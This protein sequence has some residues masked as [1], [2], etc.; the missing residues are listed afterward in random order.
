MKLEQAQWRLF[1]KKFFVVVVASVFMVTP[2]EGKCKNSVF[3]RCYRGDIMALRGIRLEMQFWLACAA[4][5]LV[6]VHR[7][8]I[9]GFKVICSMQSLENVLCIPHHC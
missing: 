1:V 5:T 7:E 3:S 4:F 9:A 2:G 6:P 8:K